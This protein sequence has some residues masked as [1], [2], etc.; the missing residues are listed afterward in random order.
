MNIYVGQLPYS[1]TE[2]DLKALFTEFGELESVKIISDRGTGQ[3]KGFGFVDMPNNSD[4]D[5]A[6]KALNGKV[7]DGR[8]IKVIPADPGGK[9]PKKSKRPFGRNRY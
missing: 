1:V 7:I 4:A 8:N 5:K 3:S 2:D 9:K 6:I